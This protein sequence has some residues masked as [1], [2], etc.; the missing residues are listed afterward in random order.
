MHAA[1]SRPG[2]KSASN[3]LRVSLASMNYPARLV[4]GRVAARTCPAAD[5]C[6]T[7]RG[8]A[9]KTCPKLECRVAMVTNEASDIGR[10]SE[11]KAAGDRPH[12]KYERLIARSKEGSGA[13]T[14]VVRP[15]GET[16]LRG[17]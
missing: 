9:H 11:L 7:A 3:A 15:L 17:A 1:N 4:T 14:I 2:T 6:M 8:G 10:V 13:T 5:E 16:S 12:A